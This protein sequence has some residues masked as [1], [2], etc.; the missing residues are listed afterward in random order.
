MK[1]LTVLFLTFFLLACTSQSIQTVNKKMDACKEGY[2]MALN[3]DIPDLIENVIFQII[4]KRMDGLWTNS[5]DIEDVLS[6]LVIEGQTESI[7]EK[8]LLAMSYLTCKDEVC[9]IEI[10][11]G[12]HDPDKMFVLLKSYLN[13]NYNL[14]YSSE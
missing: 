8:A 14:R 1:I 9:K 2:L 5:K 3:S 4:L 12:Y 13:D 6:R 10:K 11:A 7:R